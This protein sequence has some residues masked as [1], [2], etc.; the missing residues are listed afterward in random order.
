MSRESYSEKLQDPRWQKKRLEVFQRDKWRCCICAKSDVTLH[1]HHSEYD[2]DPWDV[3][4]DDLLTACKYCHKRMH[5][6]TNPIR[7]IISEFTSDVGD[8]E[9]GKF[10]TERLVFFLRCKASEIEKLYPP[11]ETKVSCPEGHALGAVSKSREADACDN[12]N[13]PKSAQVLQVPEGLDPGSQRMPQA[14]PSVPIQKMEMPV[15]G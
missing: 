4:I 14:R 11:K 13:T 8:E 3:S 5:Q 10:H 15:V 7:D 6:L 9:M 2:G 1:V 12:N